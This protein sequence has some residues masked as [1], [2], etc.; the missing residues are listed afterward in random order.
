MDRASKLDKLSKEE[1]DELVKRLHKAQNGLC[2]VCGSVLNLLVHEPDIDH[3]IALARNGADN[4]SNWGLTHSTCNRSK[5]TRD[6]RLQRLL[7]QFKTHVDKYT[8]AKA[9]GSGGDFTLYEAMKEFLPAQQDVGCELGNDAVSLSWTTNGNPATE[10]YHLLEEKSSPPARSFVAMLPFEC[11]HHDREINP[12]SIVDLEPMMRS[13]QRVSQLRPTKHAQLPG[14]SGK[15]KILCLRP[16]QS[17]AVVRR[18][19]DCLCVSS[20]RRQEPPAGDNYRPHEARPGTF[21]S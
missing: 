20:E 13:S 16:A 5:G 1:R 4:E 12:R 6:L 7:Y 15:A 3:I 9:T 10:T 14:T 18:R 17:C 19:S 11:L 2:Y 21:L 8:S